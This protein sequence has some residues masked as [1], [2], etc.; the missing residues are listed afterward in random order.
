M[1]FTKE[2]QIK[3]HYYTNFPNIGKVCFAKLIYIR[4]NCNMW[5]TYCFQR[6]VCV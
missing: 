3:T 4:F 1:T 2:I 5:E 6:H